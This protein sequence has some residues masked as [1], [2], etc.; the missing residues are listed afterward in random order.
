[1]KSTPQK[2]TFSFSTL[3]MLLMALET[4]KPS[5]PELDGVL[6]AV[7]ASTEPSTGN[8]KEHLIIY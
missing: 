6:H 3:A 1:M 8:T 7:V 4:K 5:R 2:I